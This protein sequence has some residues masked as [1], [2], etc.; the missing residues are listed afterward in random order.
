MKT[1]SWR[2]QKWVVA[3]LRANSFHAWAEGAGW[4]MPLTRG[5]DGRLNAP[6]IHGYPQTFAAASR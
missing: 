1:V 6:Q 5:P 4:E 3:E 2:R